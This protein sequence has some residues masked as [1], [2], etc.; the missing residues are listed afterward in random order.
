MTFF[1]KGLIFGQPPRLRHESRPP[2]MQL[3]DG[4]R[5][6]RHAADMECLANPDCRAARLG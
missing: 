3:A 6:M 5:S 2:E 4:V 1:R